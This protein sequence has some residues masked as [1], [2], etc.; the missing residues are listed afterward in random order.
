MRMV[1]YKYLLS[2]RRRYASLALSLAL[3]HASF[4]QVKYKSVGNGMADIELSLEQDQK[5]IS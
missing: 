5:F 1:R 3:A 4:G 2:K